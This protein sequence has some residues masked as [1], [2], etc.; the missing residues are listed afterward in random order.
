MCAEWRQHINAIAEKHKVTPAQIIEWNNL[1]D[2]TIHQGTTLQIA[3]EP[4]ETVKM[5]LAQSPE[6]KRFSTPYKRAI[7]YLTL[8]KVWSFGRKFERMEPIIYS[9]HRF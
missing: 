9:I 6:L 7:T 1:T 2:T 3:Y 4:K 8:P 5:E